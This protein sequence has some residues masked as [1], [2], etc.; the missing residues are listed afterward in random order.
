MI[1]PRCELKDY[2]RAKREDGIRH[3]ATTQQPSLEELEE[4]NSDSGCEATDGCWVEP[5]GVCEHG[6]QS[7]LRAM[8]MI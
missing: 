8:G 3:R 1:C 4:W 7:W 2:G 5:D 6:H